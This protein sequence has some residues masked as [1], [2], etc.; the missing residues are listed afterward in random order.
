MPADVWAAV[1][2][3]SLG[4]PIKGSGRLVEKMP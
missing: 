2:F 3:L 1:K 4:E